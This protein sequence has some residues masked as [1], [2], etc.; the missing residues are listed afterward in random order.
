MATYKHIKVQNGFVR[1][2]QT[3]VSV[4][5][6]ASA[7]LAVSMHVKAKTIFNVYESLKK[8]KKRIL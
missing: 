8:E 7:T 3:G 6:G 4:T 5:V 2:T 1:G